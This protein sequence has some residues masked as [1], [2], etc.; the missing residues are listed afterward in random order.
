[1]L[2]MCCLALQV[3]GMVCGVV[4]YRSEVCDAMLCYVMLCY[5]MLCYV[6]LCYAV[7]C[8]V[9]SCYTCH[10]I[11]FYDMIFRVTLPCACNDV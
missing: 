1:M 5:V 8:Y 11:L 2:Q 9:T 10:H 6:M 7:L 3:H 4:L